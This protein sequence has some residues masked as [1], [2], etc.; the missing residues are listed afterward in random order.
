LAH[1]LRMDR[2]PAAR[3]TPNVLM[4]RFDLY[5]NPSPKSRGKS[6][7]LLAVQSDNLGGLIS[8]VVIPLTRVARNYTPGKV[9][10]DLA[11]I[12]EIGGEKFVLET[13]FLGDRNQGARCRD[14]NAQIRTEPSS[15]GT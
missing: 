13:P 2:R 12:I 9:A 6:P 14:R 1:R 8:R 15:S 11:L 7:Y 5:E 4:A 10:Q 3:R